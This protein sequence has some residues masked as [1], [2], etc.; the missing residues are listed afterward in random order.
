M[1]FR[2]RWWIWILAVVVLAEGVALGALLLRS[3]WAGEAAGT[4]VQRGLRQAERMGCFGCH[5]PGGAG[6]VANPGSA[7]SSVPAWNDGTWMMYSDT[8]ADVRAWIVD[9]H[10]PGTAPEPKALLQMPAYKGRLSAGELDDLTAYV[11][12]VMQFGSLEG[13]ASEGQG[14]AKRLGCFGCHGSE[15]RG[16][17]PNPGSLKGYTPP[18]DGADYPELVR[19]PAEFRQWVQNGITD[20][21]RA[22]PA[23]RHFVE[24]EVVRMPAYGDKVSDADLAAL[25]AYVDWVRAHPRSSQ[26]RSN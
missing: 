3:R 26:S 25:Q 6:G 20:R 12:T 19:G 4:P 21:F 10:A 15:G 7:G 8:E 23:A 14:A 17:I 1:T 24:G 13:K 18:W 2:L 16:L 11:L 5:G 9:G 22:N